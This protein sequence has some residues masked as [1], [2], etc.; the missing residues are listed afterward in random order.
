MVARGQGGLV[1]RYE[2]AFYKMMNSMALEHPGEG[3]S[4]KCAIRMREKN[5]NLH[6][7]MMIFG[8]FLSVRR[9]SARDAVEEPGPANS[10]NG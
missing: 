5:S 1:N 10:L 8:L 4:A 6:N 2:R 7:L 3:V 9:A